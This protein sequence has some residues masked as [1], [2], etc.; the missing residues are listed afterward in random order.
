M[1]FF[2]ILHIFAFPWKKY[3]IKNSDSPNAHYSGG[4]LGLGAI[5]DALNPVDVV[6]AV[7]R[8]FRWLF[9]GRKHRTEDPSYANTQEV[10]VAGGQKISG[11]YAMEETG[12]NPSKQMTGESIEMGRPPQHRLTDE[13]EEDRAALLQH[14]QQIPIS[15]LESRPLFV[16]GGD[17]SA[18][19]T[20]PSFR[21]G[22]QG[23][24]QVPPASPGFAPPGYIDQGEEHYGQYYH[25]SSQRQQQSGVVGSR[26]EQDQRRQQSS[27]QQQHQQQQQQYQQQS[28]GRGA[29]GPP[30]PPPG[31]G[32]AF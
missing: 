32:Q 14:P 29:G 8:G 10:T 20:P 25:Q 15:S 19:S 21:G 7:A 13:S 11:P 22:Q 23:Y 24:G 26:L 18:T 5:I 17:R 3:S 27:Q 1:A 4:F 28:D 31:V 16:D 9:V 6:K 12:Y 30:H 2:S